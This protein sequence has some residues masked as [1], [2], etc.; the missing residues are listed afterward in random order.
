MKEAEAHGNEESS[1]EDDDEMDSA[2][3]ANSSTP[4]LRR[5]VNDQW[6]Y[7]ICENMCMC[8]FQSTIFY[9]HPLNLQII[10]VYHLREGFGGNWI[11]V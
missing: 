1:S 2:A 6:V 4:R 10:P 11:V 7:T 9:V 8:L 3:I 5:D